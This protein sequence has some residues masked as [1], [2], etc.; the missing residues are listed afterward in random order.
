MARRPRCD[1]SPW[2]DDYPVM[3]VCVRYLSRR[4]FD[5]RFV[6]DIFGW[7]IVNRYLIVKVINWAF[8]FVV[9]KKM[10]IVTSHGR[11]Q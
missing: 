6:L 9:I 5:L 10:V 8:L 7:E 2:L 4:F 3:Q 11:D 1:A